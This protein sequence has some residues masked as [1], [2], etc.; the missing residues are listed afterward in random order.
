MKRLLTMVALAAMA[1][2]SQ[3]DLLA[4]FGLNETSGNAAD[5]SGH[6]YQTQAVFVGDGL[7]YG[8]SSVNAGGYG[9]ITVSNDQAAAFGTAIDFGTADF[10]DIGN[11]NVLGTGRDAIQ[12]LLAP[13]TNGRVVDGALTIM[14]WV[15]NDF[16]S[17]Y[18]YERTI[19]NSGFLGG[20]RFGASES[21]LIFAT[22]DG[23]QITMNAAL[24]D[25]QWY[26]MAAAVQ[27]GAVSLYLNGNLLGAANLTAAYHD[28][29]GE[30]K[31]GG[32]KFGQYNMVGRMDEVKIFSSALSAAEIAAAALP[33]SP[34]PEPSSALMSAAGLALLGSLAKRLRRPDQAKSS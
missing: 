20:W 28:E 6:G 15:R 29:S 10:F 5:S 30:A 22:R 13:G 11:F 2:A 16:S 24:D 14:A 21:Q 18:F 7:R 4:H 17:T 34:V 8:L 1:S 32:Y 9:A 12:A 23:E 31:I 33:T 26:H 25:Q 19:F 3:A 27:D